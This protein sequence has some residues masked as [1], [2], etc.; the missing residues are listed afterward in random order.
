MESNPIE[1]KYDISI[2]EESKID[3]EMLFGEN[4]E[5]SKIYNM[6][7][8]YNSVDI[9]QI[10][11]KQLISDQMPIMNPIMHAANQFI[12][13]EYQIEYKKEMDAHEKLQKRFSFLN[14]IKNSDGKITLFIFIDLT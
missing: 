11:E 2:I 9:S 3:E 14:L 6:L 10:D 7:D 12:M 8:G 5:Q 1:K 13:K 4:P